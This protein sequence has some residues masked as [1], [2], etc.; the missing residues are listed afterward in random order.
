M[1]NTKSLDKIIFKAYIKL[2]LKPMQ[3][4]GKGKIDII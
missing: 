2:Q 1:L 4:F 3:I